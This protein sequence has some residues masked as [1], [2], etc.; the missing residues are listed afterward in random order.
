MRR[1]LGRFN[2]AYSQTDQSIELFALV[3]GDRSLQ[4]LDFG[5]PLTYEHDQR[6][7]G[8][9]GDPGIADQLRI[10]R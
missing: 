5:K 9:A 1:E 4:I 10:E 8:N 2:L 7:I 3:G 6:H